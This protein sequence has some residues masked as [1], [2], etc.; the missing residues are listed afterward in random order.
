MKNERLDRVK[1]H[2][3]ENR[4]LYVGTGILLTS[5]IIIMRSGNKTMPN[6]VEPYVKEFLKHHPQHAGKTLRFAVVGKGQH[7]I[8]LPM[9]LMSKYKVGEKYDVIP[10]SAPVIYGPSLV[11]VNEIG[12]HLAVFPLLKGKL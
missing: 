8:S 1:K 3:S 5:A 4:N 11:I 10:S 2:I 6:R 9:E 7:L 12:K